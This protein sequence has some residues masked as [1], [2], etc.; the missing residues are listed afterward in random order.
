MYN[1]SAFHVSVDLRIGME[2][3]QKIIYILINDKHFMYWLNSIDL[4]RP[5]RVLLTH[6]GLVKPYW[7]IDL[8]QHWLGQWLV[9][10][11]HQTI[12]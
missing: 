6:C 10:L 11:R 12:T 4:T 9:A 2:Y 3:T 1:I 8:R 7:D 5:I